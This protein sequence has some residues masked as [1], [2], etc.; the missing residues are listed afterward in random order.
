MKISKYVCS[1]IPPTSRISNHSLEQLPTAQVMLTKVSWERISI[2]I[3][4][5][6]GAERYVH[7]QCAQRV[8]LENDEVNDR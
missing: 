6:A 4:I 3:L 8:S 7:P 1:P 2:H 5:R